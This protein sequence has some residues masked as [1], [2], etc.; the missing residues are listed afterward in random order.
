MPPTKSTLNWRPALYLVLAMILVEGTAYYVLGTVMGEKTYQSL[1]IILASMLTVAL[2]TAWWVLLSK[3]PWKYRLLGIAALLLGAVTLN[4]S[5]RFEGFSGDMIPQYDFSWSPTETE[6]TARLQDKTEPASPAATAPSA[7]AWQ[8]QDNDW[9]Q[10]R[11][12]ERDGIVRHARVPRDWRPSEPLWKIPIGLGW[13]SFAVVGDF[14]FTQEQRGEY[15]AI[16]CYDSQTGRLRWMHQ[17]R[18]RFS[19]SLGGDGPR[20]TP[21]FHDGYLYCQGATGILDCLNART[22]QLIWTRNILTDAGAANIPWGMAGSPLIHGD[23]VIVSPGG[24]NSSSL[25]AYDRISGERVWGGGASQASYSSPILQRVWDEEQIWIFNGKGLFAHDPADGRVLWNFPYANRPKI[26]V[27]QPIALEPADPD[28]RS[29]YVALPT[30]Y[31]TGTTMLRL[32]QGTGADHDWKI[33]SQW[34]SRYLKP[35]FSTVVVKGQ[36]AYGAD[37]GILTC[38]DFKNQGKR[39]WKDGRYGYGQL[40]LLGDLLLIQAESGDVVLVEADPER[41][42]ETSRFSALEGKTWNHPAIGNSLLLLR[43]GQEAC[44]FRLPDAPEKPK[45]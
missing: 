5:L 33:Q 28:D 11:G 39:R 24:S 4:Y 18:A 8:V 36:Y 30:G 42:R 31:S 37:E 9:P 44:A 20:A 23:L 6:L 10:Y 1:S 40:L 13:S 21:T 14:A 15:E 43:N 29:V 41:F 3:T 16:T 12:P 34:K 45:S 17:N 22:G 38:I 26:N 35:K 2:L 27:A 19:E 32:S 7:T 25:V